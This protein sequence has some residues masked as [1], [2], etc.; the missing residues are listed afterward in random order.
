MINR[1]PIYAKL[2]AFGT[3]LATDDIMYGPEPDYTQRWKS[4]EGHWKTKV[5]LDA[6]T[7]FMLLS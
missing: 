7:I 5:Q 1:A 6:R 3:A 2:R 4:L